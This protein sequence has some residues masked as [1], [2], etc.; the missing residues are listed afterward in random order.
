MLTCTILFYLKI[1]KYLTKKKKKEKNQFW[2]SLF[3]QIPE[4]ISGQN[5]K[6][7]RLQNSH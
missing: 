1:G 7:S 4:V 2:F 3:L 5:E 6:H